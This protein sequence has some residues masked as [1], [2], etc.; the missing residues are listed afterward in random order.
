[1]SGKG[2]VLRWARCACLWFRPP[3]LSRAIVSNMYAA[4]Y[5]SIGLNQW[6][7]IW[8]VMRTRFMVIE[9]VLRLSLAEWPSIEWEEKS[10]FRRIFERSKH[11]P[12]YTAPFAATFLRFRLLTS[13]K[14]VGKIGGKTSL[15]P[16][17]KSD[18][19][20]NNTQ[21]LFFTLSIRYFLFFF[22]SKLRI[23]T[24]LLLVICKIIEY[25]LIY[26]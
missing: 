12:L 25:F 19:L 9:N 22:P 6:A 14:P 26:Y 18:Y 21:E 23:L 17:N 2:E 16:F 13:L 15:V 4:Q 20:K 5:R 24:F 1:M 3:S 11:S 7:S 8:V 10:R